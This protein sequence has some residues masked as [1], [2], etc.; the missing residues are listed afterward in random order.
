L[1]LVSDFFSAP[2]VQRFISSDFRNISLYKNHMSY[3]CGGIWTLG[4]LAQVAISQP[5]A[6][7]S[8]D[9]AESAA[10]FAAARMAKMLEGQAIINR[11]LAS[12]NSHVLGLCVI[13][14]VE[15]L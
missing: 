3:R 8:N 6:P 13:V 14:S 11:W 2:C 12:L 5:Q 15:S 9:P 4:L 1:P 7:D 10:T